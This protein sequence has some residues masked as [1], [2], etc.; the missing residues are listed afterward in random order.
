MWGVA[1]SGVLIA[2][3]ISG[4]G[5]G[6][7]YPGIYSGNEKKCTS[8]SEC[9]EKVDSCLAHP[10]QD[11][12][13]HYHITS[14]CQANAAAFSSAKVDD[15]LKTVRTYETKYRSVYGISKDG[16]AIYSIYYS[17]GMTYSGCQV[18]VCN[19]LK[20][21]G[22]YSYVATLFHPYFMGCYGIGNN[23]DYN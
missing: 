4:E 5:A 1:T 22:V 16:R 15:V 13:F 10:Q 11:G 14:P 6:P 21:N 17:G 23:P 8:V 19:G 20:I 3:G 18:D 2:N 9:T 12:I 7:F